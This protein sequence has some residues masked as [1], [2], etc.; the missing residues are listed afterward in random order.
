[1]VKDHRTNSE[2]GTQSE[3]GELPFIE[4]T[5]LG[6]ILMSKEARRVAILASVLFLLFSLFH[7][8]QNILPTD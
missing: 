3:D 1:M 7:F 5:Q 8:Y 6:G 2:R 4:H